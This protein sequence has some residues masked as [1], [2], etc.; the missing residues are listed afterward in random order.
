MRVSLRRLF[1]LLFMLLC[2]VALLAQ[3]EEMRKALAHADE[4]RSSYDHSFSRNLPGA[5]INF[6]EIERKGTPGVD[7]SIKYELNVC[8]LPTYLDYDL[9]DWPNYSD[10]PKTEIIGVSLEEDGK[11]VCKGETAE[12][13]KFTGIG[14]APLDLTITNVERGEPFRFAV[15]SGPRNLMVVGATIPLPIEV[16]EGSCRIEAIRLMPHFEVAWLKLSGFTP[17]STLTMDGSSY[18]ERHTGTL[19]ANSK[20]EGELLLLPYVKGQTWGTSVI[21]VTDGKCSPKISFE[22]GTPPIHSAFK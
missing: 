12:Q 13:C 16:N 8:C 5:R 22:W 20:G 21:T 19:R 11:V 6:H 1:G 2:S 18:G 4:L 9:A 17:S 15:F 7:L 10:H 14:G 3:D